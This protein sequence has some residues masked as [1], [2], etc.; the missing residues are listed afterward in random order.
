MII[1]IALVANFAHAE[2][3]YEFWL[4]YRLEADTARRNE[5]IQYCGGEVVA[6]ESFKAGAAYLELKRALPAILG[7]AFQANN[8]KA[9]SIYVGG[10]NAH[11][12]IAS[13]VGA[14]ELA[15]VGEEGFVLRT[16]AWEGRPATIIAANSTRG[17]LY[18]TFALLR[19]LQLGG[20]LQGLHVVDAPKMRHRFANHWDNPVRGSI[21]RG[22]GGKS[23]FDWNALPKKVDSR[24]N[25]WARMLA[26]MRL[27][28]VV[29]NNVNTAKNGLEGWRLLT[30]EFLPKLAAL[31]GVLRPYGVKLYISVNFFSPSIVGSLDTADP[32]DARVRA[33]WKNKA[34]EIYKVI[35]DF[36]GFLVKADS[37]GEPGPL[38]YKRTHAEGANMLAEALAPHGGYVYWRAFVYNAKGDRTPQ[39]Y[40]QFKPL[41]GKFAKNVFLQVK[42]GPV[43]FQVREPISTLFGAMPRTDLAVEFQITQEYTGQDRHVCF[44]GQMWSDVLRFPLKGEKNDARMWNT[45]DA[46]AG[47]MNI[48]DSRN[49]T[50]HLLAQANTYAFGRLA[51][52]PETSP[53]EIA[54]D[55]VR[56][57]FGRDPVVVKTI[58]S[59][60]RDSWPAYEN[61]T[62]PFGIGMLCDRGKHIDPAPASR[63]SVHRADAKGFGTNRT[64]A[65]GSGYAGQFSEPWR[66]RYEKLGTCPEELLLFF[67]HVP[68]THK[69]KNGTTVIQAFYDRHNEGVAT[70]RDFTERWKALNK[71][72]D[73]ERYEHVRKKLSEQAG[74]AEKWR[75][76]IN[77]YFEKR[78]GIPDAGGGS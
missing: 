10:R 35:P 6:P 24:L 14:G 22:Y 12:A 40:N 52:N 69:L 59:I 58:V 55:W 70:A 63:G 50:G 20:S 72:I 15:G 4:R 49:W 33:W 57:T 76:S 1:G 42:N 54:S 3:G 11:P 46:I 2:D 7:K 77:D 68:Y 48:N 60:L 44:L 45:T 43:D 26:S 13:L 17:I 8:A 38:K 19:T 23:I 25:D 78:S 31:A 64:A 29:V 32:A 30:P 18:G 71:L 36:G 56:L 37:E 67:H 65:K 39:A 62:S 21:E 9:G 27:N 75:Q 73:K 5:Y 61:Y 74:H 16:G 34:A 51:W 28:A 66:S 41:D 53:D 47:V